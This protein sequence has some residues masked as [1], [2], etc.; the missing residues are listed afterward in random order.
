[1]S[2]DL[3][4]L[5]CGFTG[6][7]VARRALAEGQ[8]VIGTVRSH[9]RAVS[10]LDD[11]TLAG[12]DVRVSPWLE[13]SLASEADATTHVVIA[14][15]PDGETD[16]RLAP[17]FAHAAAV[18]YVSSTGVYGERTG[19]LDDTTKLPDP[20]SPRA[21]R[22][23]DAEQAWRAVGATVLRCPGIYGPE[24]GLHRRILRGEHK[25]PG[26]GSRTL[27][28]IHVE[29]LA[30]FILAARQT[31]GK[32]FV[33]GDLAPAPHIE[34]VRWVCE[35][36]GVPLPPSQPWEEVHETLRADRAV[37][38]ARAREVLGVTLRYPSYREGMA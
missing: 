20:P 3:L 12:L 21:R 29:D 35:R 38:S 31:R 28:R 22:I 25:I 14:F 33:V 32:T 2:A 9:A 17:A 13:P 27:S 8:H 26:D 7:T 23:L 19:H 5:G 11:G 15:P 4:V 18:T 1:M 36:H 37:D 30:S 24:R 10:L 6:S 16:A 34:V